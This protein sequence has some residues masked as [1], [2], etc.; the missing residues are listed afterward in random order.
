[1]THSGRLL[2]V[3]ALA[4]LAAAT[5]FATACK[6]EEATVVKQPNRTQSQVETDTITPLERGQ[7]RTAVLRDV[8]AAIDAWQE[9]DGDTMR[10]YMAEDLVERFEN[11]WSDYE[12]DGLRVAH[13]HDVAYLDVIELNIDGT[14]ALVTYR[15]DDSSYLVDGSSGDRVKNL[16][17]F[18]DKEM[19]LTI[20]KQD[21]GSWLIVRVIAADDAFR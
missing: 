6:P 8:R 14:Q 12:A 17:A 16:P 13:V 20:D 2:K 15:Y 10:L 19:Q 9:S 1:M 5:L 4:V 18:S 3:A 11:T 7:I 21:D